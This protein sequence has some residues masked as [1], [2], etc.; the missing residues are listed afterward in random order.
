[1]YGPLMSSQSKAAIS[2]V[3]NLGISID[4]HKPS[5]SATDARLKPSI[6]GKTSS[7]DLN[8]SDGDG[9]YAFTG[10]RKTD[11]NDYVLY[12]DPER[13][14]F[15]LD[16]VDSTFNMNVT[17]I[18]GNT[19]PHDLKQRY[20]QL[21]SQ[22]SPKIAPVKETQKPAPKPSAKGSA[23][24]SAVQNKEP[25]KRTEKKQAPKK[26]DLALPVPAAP[27]PQP[28][29]RRQEQDDEDEEDEDDDG[30]L[31]VEYPGAESAAKQTDFSPAFPAPRRFDD[32]MDQRESEA[33]DADGESDS[34]PDLDFKLPSPVNGHHHGASQDEHPLESMEID[35]G[36]E[37]E[38]V[39]DLEDDLEKEM[40]IAFEDLQ[41][42]HDGTPNGG[43]ESEISEED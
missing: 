27:K 43:D 37:V 6:P 25:K 32:F 14:A 7:Y 22:S 39:A 12:F 30:D 19:D 31:L 24:S 8:F 21:N 41:N 34:E 10:A 3:A 13:Q 33:D 38:S 28:K 29:P 9:V 36:E 1:M 40:E 23:K 15:I 17:R 42:S 2:L 5:M 18:P 11:D 4:N 35:H 26:M 16:K 20:P